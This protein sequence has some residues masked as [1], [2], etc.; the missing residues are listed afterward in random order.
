MAHIKLM[1]AS[2]LIFSPFCN[3][4]HPKT[5]TKHSH[6]KI[7]SIKFLRISVELRGARVLTKTGMR[8]KQ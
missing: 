6:S 5:P 4:S 1:T 2:M 3:L 8:I 7:V